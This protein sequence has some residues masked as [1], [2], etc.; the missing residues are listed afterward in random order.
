MQYC[1]HVLLDHE[2]SVHVALVNFLTDFEVAL[3]LASLQSPAGIHA[4]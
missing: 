1:G 3:A 2:L 4:A